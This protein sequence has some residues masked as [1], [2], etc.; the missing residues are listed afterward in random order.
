LLALLALLSVFGD[1]LSGVFL[2]LLALICSAV[3]ALN[4]LT[5]SV[6][7]C[8]S[9][10]QVFR[11]PSREHLDEGFDLSVVTKTT[12][13]LCRKLLCMRC[14][15]NAFTV[16]TQTTI[17]ETWLPSSC[18]AMDGRSDSDIIWLLGGTPHYFKVN[19]I[20]A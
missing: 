19:I 8:N 12:L 2:A 1:L 9:L 4:S 18:L 3:L 15:V 11:Q 16:V 10:R 5:V 17:R 14:R 7:V 20:K 13:P 6:C